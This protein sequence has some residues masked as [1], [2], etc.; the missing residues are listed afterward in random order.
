MDLIKAVSTARKA[1][2]EARAVLLKYYGHLSKV[3][4]KG[5]EGLVSEADEESEKLITR[6]LTEAFPD[7]PVLGEEGA[8]LEGHYVVPDTAW[9]V[10]PLDGTTN[11][12][13]GFSVFCISIGLRFKGEIVAAVIDA[14]VLNDTYWA[15][16][17]GG[18]FLN[19]E[20]LRVS[21]RDQL[22]DALLSTGFY[23]HNRPDLEE[24]IRIFSDLVGDVR[25]VRRPGA[26]AYDLCMVAQGVFDGFWEKNL[27]PWDTA[28]GI[29]LVK[30]AG[31]RVLN[32]EGNDY[33]VTDKGLIATNAKLLQP[34]F[35]R[36]RKSLDRS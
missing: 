28:A 22:K 27:K 30:E 33:D 7:I 29:L 11:Y 26:A 34:I 35:E 19:G 16:Q 9:I 20:P 25:G 4:E 23:P 1:A 13:H 17:G 12:I 36:M 5:V 31:G 15:H 2:T 10:D 14:P 6:I 3:R 21:E 18:A 24:Q 32:Y 8:A